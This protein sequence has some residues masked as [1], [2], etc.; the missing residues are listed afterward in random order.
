MESKFPSGEEQSSVLLLFV[1]NAEECPV[2]SRES[3]HV[4][5]DLFGNLKDIVLNSFLR[6]IDV[7]NIDMKMIRSSNFSGLED[8]Q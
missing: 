6:P 4:L 8:L 2:S 7:I 5:L 3:L 1:S